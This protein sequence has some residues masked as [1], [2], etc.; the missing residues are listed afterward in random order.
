M[1]YPLESIL[2]RQ[3]FS[4][5]EL[6]LGENLCCSLLVSLASIQRSEFDSRTSYKDIRTGNALNLLIDVTESTSS[7]FS[8]P[9]TKLARLCST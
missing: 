7:H 4:M 2:L 9:N 5:N 8:K 6:D 1:K 3:L